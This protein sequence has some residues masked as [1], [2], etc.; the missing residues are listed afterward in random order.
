LAATDTPP[1][2]T[3]ATLA[4]RLN[5]ECVGDADATIRGIGSLLDATADELAFLGNPRYAA[6]VPGSAAAIVLVPTDYTEEPGPGRAWVRC[7]DPSAAFAEIARHYTPPPLSFPPGT[8]PSAVIA[9]SAIVSASAYVGENVVIQADAVIGE[10]CVLEAGVVIGLESRLGEDCRIYPNTTIR[11]R[12]ILGNRVH[13]HSGSVI[14]SD[15]FGYIS[16]AAGHAKI[17]QSGIVRI[18]DDVE[19]GACVTVDRARFEQTWIQRGVKID[20]QVQIAHNVVIGENSIIVSQSGVSGSSR[21]GNW[22]TVAGQA[23][24]PGHTVIGDGVTLMAR[25]GPIRDITEPGYYGGFPAVPR[26]EFLRRQS[27]VRRLPELADTVKAL[28]RRIAEL[29]ARLDADASQS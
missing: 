29:E 3:A 16:S 18:D 17:E 14:G 26:R 24:V 12:C 6:Q 1:S 19:L 10:R 20:N 7:A 27:H 5:G 11:E 25:C 4:E 21:L 2:F 28:Q 23:G 8:H 22:V 15:G 9:D 13:I